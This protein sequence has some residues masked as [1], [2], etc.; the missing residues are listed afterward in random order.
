[1][2]QSILQNMR[3]YS[4]TS[5]VRWVYLYMIRGFIFQNPEKYVNLEIHVLKC[6]RKNSD[7]ELEI[8]S[9]FQPQLF[10]KISGIRSI[11]GK[12]FRVPTRNS[13]QFTDPAWNLDKFPGSELKLGKFQ[14]SGSDIARRPTPQNVNINDQQRIIPYSLR[15]I[16]YEAGEKGDWPLIANADISRL[17][18][19]WQWWYNDTYMGWGGGGKVGSSIKISSYTILYS[20]STPYRLW[21]FY[22]SIKPRDISEFR[23]AEP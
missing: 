17:K 1:M 20:V 13:E 7:L 16:Q 8:I 2:V 22:K 14:D 21:P 11:T 19:C 3:I 23:V 5:T 15:I 10:R 9:G 4:N 18:K 12:N 6:N